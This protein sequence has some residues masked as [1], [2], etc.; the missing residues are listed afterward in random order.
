VTTW[1]DE[2]EED[3]S[4]VLSEEARADSAPVADVLYWQRRPWRP[5]FCAGYI[6]NS[7]RPVTRLKWPKGHDKKQFLERALAVPQG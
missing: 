4:E 1:E 3:E 5:G 6:I 7:S 2:P